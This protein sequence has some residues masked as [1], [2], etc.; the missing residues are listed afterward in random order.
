MSNFTDFFPAAGGGGGFTKMNKYSTLRS[1]DATN[2]GAIPTT[3]NVSGDTFPPAT[4]LSGRPVSGADQTLFAFENSLVGCKF[5]NNATEHTVTANA[6]NSAGSYF[7]IT[8]TPALTGSIAN[9]VNLSF[10]G[11]SITV[12]PVTDLGLADGASIGYFLC[13]AGAGDAGK[14]GKINYGT[15]IISNASTDLVLTPGV[16]G[17]SWYSQGGNSTITGGLTLT[18]GDGSN[19]AGGS[20][21]YYDYLGGY[22]GILGYGAGGG[23]GNSNSGSRG[24]QNHG[25]GGG[26]FSGETAGDGAILLN[27]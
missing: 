4:T 19:M 27:Y 5:T 8:F 15:A 22:A 17:L 9:N 11:A 14:G 10:S 20:A 6:N 12:N 25:W 24:N 7:T 26:G 1:A 18:S 3:I 13:G 16:A 21:N 2:K 23:A